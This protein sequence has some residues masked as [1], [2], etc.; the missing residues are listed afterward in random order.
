MKR[1]T[2]GL[3]VMFLFVEMVTSCNLGCSYCDSNGSTCY[4]CSDPSTKQI[5]DGTC[6]AIIR[7]VDNCLVYNPD[8]SCNR[9]IITYQLKNGSCLVDQTGCTKYSSNG[10]CLKCDFGTVLNGS[11]CTGIVNCR[12]YV[13]G[14]RTYCKN[15]FNGFCQ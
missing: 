2:L 3:L 15:C 10:G 7:P 9:C 11:S 4:A 1:I 5:A 13:P 14:G 12:D 6:I 8:F